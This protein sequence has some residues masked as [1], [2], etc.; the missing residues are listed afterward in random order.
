METREC[1]HWKKSW[2]SQMPFTPATHGGA[3]MF[4]LFCC[5]TD[6]GSPTRICSSACL[7]FHPAFFFFFFFAP[8]SL[9]A[10]EG[11]STRVPQ[12][13]LRAADGSFSIQRMAHHQ[14]LLHK[15]NG[16][17]GK[18]VGMAFPEGSVCPWPGILLQFSMSE[19]SYQSVHDLLLFPLF[20][21][22]SWV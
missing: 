15:E 18:S 6:P 14:Q 16:N 1:F 5:V 21:N 10:M 4:S 17:Q 13:S 20:M 11:F 9:S 8:D 12:T 7:F 19:A 3:G 2:S 22:L